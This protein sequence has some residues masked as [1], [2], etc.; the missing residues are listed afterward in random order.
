MQCPHIPVYLN[1]SGLYDVEFRI[2]AACRNGVL[3]TFKRGF[4]T[5]KNTIPLSSQIAGIE[6]S[7]KNV[8]IGCMDRS[9]NCFSTKR[10]KLWRLEMPGDI[11]AMSEMNYKSKG[12]QAVIVSLSNNEVHI[13]RDKYIISKFVTQDSVVGLRFGKFGR[14]DANIIMATKSSF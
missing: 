5:P 11:L 1:A 6:R 8:I 12:I 9:L 7:G 14:E 10:K 3:Y 13:Y 4:K 2:L